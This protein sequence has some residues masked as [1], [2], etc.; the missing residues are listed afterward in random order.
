MRG[1]NGLVLACA[2]NVTCF[3]VWVVEIRLYTVWGMD[4]DIRTAEV[5]AFNLEILI[6]IMRMKM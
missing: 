3:F 5:R 6:K 4:P 1:T 2:S